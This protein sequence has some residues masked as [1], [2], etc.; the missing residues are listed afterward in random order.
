MTFASRP[1]RWLLAL[2]AWLSLATAAQAALIA[3]KEYTLLNPPQPVKAGSK[4]EVIEFFWY[5]CPHCYDLEP[6]LN[7]WLAKLPKDVEFS[8]M[9]AIFRGSWVPGARIFYTLEAMGVGEKLHGPVFD[10]IHRDNVHL[11]DDRVLIEWMG[12]Q[13]VDKAKFAETWK[14]FS[15]QSKVERAKQLTQAYQFQ[16]VPAVVVDGRYLTSVS[17]AGSPEALP[18]VLDAL[19]DKAR[20]ER[21]KK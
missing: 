13:G 9:P 7:K 14:S 17:N 11:D 3:G 4:V 21:A 15:V 18:A 1:L 5:G 16:G 8:R 2:L 20:A 19:I 10:A 12:K 6:T